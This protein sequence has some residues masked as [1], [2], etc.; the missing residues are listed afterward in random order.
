MKSA[1]QLLKTELEANKQLFK[2]GLIDHVTKLS[3]DVRAKYLY[4]T[5]IKDSE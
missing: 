3:K 2:L 5:Q 1:Y 4:V